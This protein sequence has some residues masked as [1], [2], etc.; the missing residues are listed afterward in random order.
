MIEHKVVMVDID[1]VLADFIW[2]FTSLLANL[3]GGRPY[4]TWEQW[5]WGTINGFT[6]EQVSEAWDTVRGSRSFWVGVPDLLS[7]DGVPEVEGVR[8]LWREAVKGHIDLYLVTSRVGST[9]KAQTEMWLRERNIYHP[10][11]IVSGLKGFVARGVGATAAIDDSPAQLRS[12][13]EHSPKTVVSVRDWAYN[14]CV[15]GYVGTRVG[16]VQEFVKQLEVV[17]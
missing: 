6:R 16:S 17:G 8:L 12:I 2:S 15:E 1:G 13:Y 4:H 7:S 3:F 9:A 5:D 10:T 14:R 11:V